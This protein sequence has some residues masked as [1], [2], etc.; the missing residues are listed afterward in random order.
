MI[1]MDTPI[2]FPPKPF[3]ENYRLLDKYILG[4]QDW[5]VER[6]IL[7][8]GLVSTA[9]NLGFEPLS[10]FIDC[11][12]DESLGMTTAELLAVSLLPAKEQMTCKLQALDSN[13]FEKN[14][15]KLPKLV[16]IEYA[17]Q[18]VADFDCHGKG[19]DT[20]FQRI[21]MQ[22]ISPI[23]LNMLIPMGLEK[24]R[25]T[26][27]YQW[28][29]TRCPF[30]VGGLN[31]RSRNENL[32]GKI[33]NNMY[34]EY[35]EYTMGDVY[36]LMTVSKTSSQIEK[37]ERLKYVIELQNY[38][39]DR[40]NR[41]LFGDDQL[42]TSDGDKIKRG[43]GCYPILP[44]LEGT[45]LPRN[46]ELDNLHRTFAI[47]SGS[48]L[49]TDMMTSVW[50]PDYSGDLL[51]PTL[52]HV[53]LF[54]YATETKLRKL[55]LTPGLTSVVELM[56]QM[57]LSV[58]ETGGK[59]LIPFFK[60]LDN[61]DKLEG[62]LDS[63]L[64]LVVHICKV[65][66][67]GHTSIIDQGL[68]GNHRLA[69]IAAILSGSIPDTFLRQIDKKALNV[70]LLFGDTNMVQVVPYINSIHDLYSEKVSRFS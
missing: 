64:P 36:A 43:Y 58:R 19:T 25:D 48:H 11:L 12:R 6:L 50:G 53:C 60:C 23:V 31:H 16:K 27:T 10:N 55:M 49:M 7:I 5:T 51:V 65:L 69:I 70:S 46:T 61:V 3:N 62:G 68:E 28:G 32:E 17:E 13:Y 33:L 15:N 47:Q 8:L 34:S 52:L 14:G 57:A 40:V 35:P 24:V 30:P 1:S 41:V 26:K 45:E 29:Y 63:Y 42:D 54:K 2:R 4:E 39:A 38:R 18:S 59:K 67:Q 56:R 22:G 44:T 21:H 20:C 9:F 37:E 66:I